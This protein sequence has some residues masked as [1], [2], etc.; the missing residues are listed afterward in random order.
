MVVSASNGATKFIGSSTL[1]LEAS[2]APHGEKLMFRE[3]SSL[4]I[5]SLK[6]SRTRTLYQA[7]AGKTIGGMEM[8]ANSW[9]PNGNSFIFTERDT[10]ALSTS[11]QKL[12]LINPDDGSLKTLGESPESYQLSEL[13]WSPDGSKIAATGKSINSAHVPTY[14]YWVLE[15]ILPK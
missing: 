12:F 10:S 7:P 3:R 5:S 2:W 6:E 8:Y 11:P 13:R 9:S 4:K 15:N 14:E 1:S